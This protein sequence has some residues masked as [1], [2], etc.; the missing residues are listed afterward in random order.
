[1]TSPPMRLER[2]SRR[3]RRLSAYGRTAR[4]N[5]LSFFLRHIAPEKSTV[6][7]HVLAPLNAL[8][9]F[10]LG[11]IVSISVVVGLR[12]SFASRAEVA[13]RQHAV[14][15]LAGFPRVEDKFQ[16]VSSVAQGSPSQQVPK[17]VSPEVGPR[18]VNEGQPMEGGDTWDQ[19]IS[20]GSRQAYIGARRS[21]A[22]LKAVQMPRPDPGITAH[23]MTIF[24]VQITISLCMS[25]AVV[26]FWTKSLRRLLTSSCGTAE[27]AD[28]WITYC[29]IMV[30]LAPMLSTVVFG[31]SQV[32]DGI[33]AGDIRDAFG[34]SLFGVFAALSIIGFQITRL[35]PKIDVA[36][37]VRSA[38]AVRAP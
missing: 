37:P 19:R 3:S 16:A 36:S 23:H 25:L 21:N 11:A 6:P 33:F 31:P 7:P 5:W 4:P 1:M 24:L 38:D 2:Q 14:A 29:N 15:G 35:M 10:A 28:F 32:R 18:E 30:Y 27:R 22:G 8:L 34:A 20:A 26:M 12:Y 13:Y 17:T 9:K